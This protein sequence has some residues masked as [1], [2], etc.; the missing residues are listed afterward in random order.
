MRQQAMAAGLAERLSTE[1]RK[2][3][4]VHDRVADGS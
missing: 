1:I 4:A 2:T 3:E